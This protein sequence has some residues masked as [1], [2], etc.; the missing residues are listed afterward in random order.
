MG[1]LFQNT[2][3]GLITLLLLA[4][5][6]F[7]MFSCGKNNM[8]W[9]YYDET[10]CADKWEYNINNERLKDNVTSYFDGKGV[11][12]YEVEIFNDRTAESCLEC[13]CKTGRRVKVKVKKHDVSSM[14]AENFYE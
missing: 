4:G 9:L 2:N 7:F 11:R 10:V 12:I 1:K 3:K 8:K 6:S 13:H 14:K 5:L